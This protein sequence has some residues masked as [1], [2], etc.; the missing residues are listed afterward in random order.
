MKLDSETNYS[1]TNDSSMRN[2]WESTCMSHV[3]IQ[4]SADTSTLQPYLAN[5][6]IFSL[7]NKTNL[8]PLWKTCF[9]FHQNNS[10]LPPCLANTCIFLLT[11]KTNLPPLWTTCSFFHQNNSKLP[12]PLANTC[13]VLLTNKTNL[14]PPLKNTFLCPPEPFKLPP[15]LTLANTYIFL[16]TSKT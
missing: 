13:I 9:F 12:P 3:L 15:P 4:P 16:L 10:K 7:T 2:K 6:C 14:R 5:T 1:E 8:P 11:N